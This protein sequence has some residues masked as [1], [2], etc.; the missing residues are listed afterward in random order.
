MNY[1]NEFDPAAASW[2]RELISEG[3]IPRGVVDDRSITDVTAD[4]LRGFTQCHFFAGIAGWSYAL[5]LAGWSASRPV[6]TGS[7]PC[8]RSVSP[9]N[10]TDSPTSETCGRHSSI[11]SKSATLNMS[12]ASKLKTR[13]STVGSIE[14]IETWKQ[15]ATPAGASYW[16]HTASA[17]R[18]KDNDCT[19]VDHWPKTP[20]A[21]DAEGGIMEIRPGTTGK[22]K[23]RDYAVLAVSSWPTTTNDAKNNAAPSQWSRLSHGKPRALAL[24]CEVVLAAWSTPQTMDSLECIRNVEDLPKNAGCSNLRG[25]VIQVLLGSDTNSSTAKTERFG[26]YRLNPYFSAWLMGFPKEW[27]EAGMAAF[28]KL[29]ASRSR[30]KKKVARCS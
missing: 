10:K 1:Y 23:L 30:N 16:A 25:R 29:T 11:S 17:P 28:Q 2:L 18:I 15:K 27:T 14:Y 26:G 19:G 3:L 13:L 20:M 7:C 22:Y 24:N 8:R 4:D 9:E 6:W 12:L 21:G 5:Q